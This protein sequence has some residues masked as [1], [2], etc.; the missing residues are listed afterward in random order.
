M[1]DYIFIV[2]SPR[3]GTTLTGKILN[4][5]PDIATWF[6]PYFMWEKPFRHNIDDV[7]TEK[8]ATPKV[9]Q[10]IRESFRY[11]KHK[12]GA[13][14]VI[15][16]SPRNSL[17]IS[18]IRKIFPEAKFIH[19]IREPK[20]A[21][22]SIKKEWQKRIDIYHSDHTGRLSE[23]I[24]N[25]W[26]PFQDLVGLQPVLRHK[27]KAVL[28]E[29][30]GFSLNAE[31]QYNRKRWNGK[32]GW[33]PRFQG[34]SEKIEALTLLEFN[35][36]QWKACVSDI[37]EHLPEDP[38]KTMLLKYETLLGHPQNEIARL[39][40]FIDINFRFEELVNSPHLMRE[41][42]NKWRKALRP[43]EVEAIHSILGTLKP[44]S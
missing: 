20:D 36:C 26:K 38:E 4:S 33:G 22:L 39:L 35:A 31:Q 23:R 27:I 7:L 6:V 18:F 5:H 37:I 21:I 14:Y 42:Y 8:D 44:P 32:V 24:R 40:S 41:N 13:K 43:D 12:T 10:Y 17:R 15:D 19:V 3:S 16:Q 25:I 30:Y 28:F 9:I 11:F 34:W 1:S 2:G 29:L